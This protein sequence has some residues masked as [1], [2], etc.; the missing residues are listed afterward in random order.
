MVLDVIVPGGELLPEGNYRFRVSGN[1]SIHDLSGLRLDGDRD[2]LEGGDA[3]AANQT[4]EL[5]PI[6]DRTAHKNAQLRFTATAVDPDGDA[7][8]FSLDPA[9]PAG[10]TFDPVNGVF[11]WTPG[12]AQAPGVYAI[13]IRVSD[14]GAPVLTDAETIHITVSSANNVTN[15][16]ARA[17]IDFNGDSKSDLLWRD[18]DG[19]LAIWQMDGLTI[20]GGASLGVVPTSWS[21]LD[22]HGDYNGDGKSDILWRDA[23]GTVVI[24]QMDGLAIAAGA[25]FG[26][27]PTSWSVLDGHADYNGDGKSDLLWRDADGTV[28]IWQMDGL[29]I[30][31][32]ASLGVVPTSWSMLDGHGDFNGDG[33]SDL[34]WRDADGTVAIWQMDGLAIA[35]GALLGVVPTSWS[36]LDGHGDYNGDGK[37]DLLWRD[38]DGTVAIWQMDGLAIAAGAL[39]GVVPTSWSV[40]DGHG[41]YNGDG[42]SDLLWRD[43]DGTVAIWQMDG[44]AIAGGALLGVVPTSWSMLDGHGDYNGDG[45]SDLLWRDADGTVAIWQMDGLAIAAGALLGVVPT[46]WSV[47]DVDGAVVNPAGGGQNLLASTA[48]LEPRTAS[49]LLSKEAVASIADEAVARWLALGNID[50][51][52]R[53]ALDTL[54]FEVAD[55]SGLALGTHS[56]GTLYIDIDAA[57]YGWFIDPT[58]QDSTEFHFVPGLDEWIADAHGP[59]FGRMDLLSVVTH[60]IGH[61]LGFDHGDV[62]SYDVMA[63]TLEPGVRYGADTIRIDAS[64]VARGGDQRL[65]PEESGGTAARVAS[66]GLPRFELGSGPSNDNGNIDWR[67]RYGDSWGVRLSPYASKPA[68]GSLNNISD[69]L[70][71][72]FQGNLSAGAS[73]DYDS[74]GSALLG[75]GKASRSGR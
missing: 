13:T 9:A 40:L 31:G 3:V 19:T 2:G 8:T 53:A 62:G 26:V 75:K 32:G 36:V 17:K 34:L 45:K 29:A 37:S 22:G 58:P 10:V 74:L 27:V 23:D 64:A 60:E 7:I 57:G 49:S 72:P 55:L 21:V 56:G 38:A 67:A 61:V 66:V 28:A 18:A 48:P 1:S 5:A 69:F 63:A 50:D 44:L 15:N 52:A 30:A 33:K 6:G 70:V 73:Q 24:W 46:S 54:A 68:K 39:L 25:S 41:D 43:A 65:M 47:L 59:A 42:K 12:E 16:P 14:D 11:T 35:G 71:K 20:A 51:A 4:P